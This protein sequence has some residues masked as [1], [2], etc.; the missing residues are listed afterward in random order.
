MIAS[1]QS[2]DAA[3]AM[4]ELPR[5]MIVG[6]QIRAGR[7][8][9]GWSVATL[10]TQSGISE[11]TIRRAEA[12][13]SVPSMR[14]DNLLALQRALEDGGVLFLDPGDVRTGGEGVRR[15]RQ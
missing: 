3:I 9:L 7:A 6:S 2:L 15:A 4:P 5:W 14:A 1:A 13:D 8:L 12:V 10:A 11:A